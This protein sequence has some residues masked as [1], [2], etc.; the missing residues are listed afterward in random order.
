MSPR[1]RFFSRDE[2]NNGQRNLTTRP[3]GNRAKRQSHFLS[4]PL[5]LEPLEGRLLLSVTSGDSSSEHAWLSTTENSTVCSSGDLSI[6]G[7]SGPAALLSLAFDGNLIDRSGKTPLAESGVSFQPGRLGDAAR[8]ADPGYILYGSSENVIETGGTVEFWIQPNWNGNEGNAHTFFQVGYSFDNSMLLSI[9][10]ANNLRFLQWGDNRDTPA[11]ESDYETGIGSSGES[12]AEG[13]WHHLAATWNGAT[14]EADFYVDGRSVGS[15][16]NAVRI[17]PF[18]TSHLTVGSDIYGEQ[19]A[20]AAFDE[21]C[22]WDTPLTT[23]EVLDRYFEGL[24]IQALNGP[25]G[26]AVDPAGRTFVTESG[27]NRV[28]VFDDSGAKGATHKLTRKRSAFQSW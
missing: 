22:I 16:D 10:G 15:I 28:A 25:W 26:V 13:S 11:I 27:T 21:F 3:C 9:D 12:W 19:C 7:G 1:C 17:G 14:G 24:G 4:R 8:T 6:H 23:G 20:D 18:S 5:R 2:A